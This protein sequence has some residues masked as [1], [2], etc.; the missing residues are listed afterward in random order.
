M[1]CFTHRDS[2][3]IAICRSCGRALC[4]DCISEV[5]LSCACK[6]RCEADVQR[7]NAMLTQGR[8]ALINP[9]KL[10]GYDRVAF[11]L[12]LGAAFVCF[13]LY[14]EKGHGPS[15]FFIGF[16]VLF[17]IFGVSQFVAARNIRKQL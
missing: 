5:G 3:A 12:A 15:L 7:F 10:V 8:P 14:Y 2:D 11:I 6:N 4:P 13:G 17:F 9:A 1:K 16:G